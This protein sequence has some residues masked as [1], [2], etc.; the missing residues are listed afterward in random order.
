MANDDA[1]LIDENRASWDDRAEV[2]AHGGYGDL[3]ALTGDPRAITG[4]ARRD[5]EALRPHLPNNTVEGLKLLHLQCHIGT[6]TL[7]WPRLGAAETW[8]LDFSPAALAH[9]RELARQ[10]G[11]EVRYAEGDARFAA[12]ALQDHIG[13]FDAIVTSAG[14]ITWLPDLAD[15]A[16]S[17]ER[18]L[19]PGGAFMIRD[20][21]PL[22]AALGFSGLEACCDYVSGSQS[23]YDMD[24]TYTTDPGNDATR[25][26]A[27][28]RNHNWTHDFAEIAS[29]LLGAGLSIEG[30][31]EDEV[32]EWQSLPML[33]FH[34]EDESWR[35]PQGSPRL[36]LIFTI[37]ARKPQKRNRH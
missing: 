24:V 22:L 37:V 7:C 14:T 26:L 5:Y 20:D 36:P 6:D 15:W 16:R 29:A 32:A 35:L 3:S 1:P 2:H 11:V 18:L 27:H 9:A 30:F 13:T 33:E 12:D 10:A 19:A 34:A 31:A 4:V 25:R 23:S 21:H 28:T 8:G 17:I